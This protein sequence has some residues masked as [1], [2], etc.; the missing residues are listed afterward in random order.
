MTSKTLN[1]VLALAVVILAVE[2]YLAKQNTAAIQPEETGEMPA[3]T[4]I[5]QR[6][7]V[8]AYSDQPVE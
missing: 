5:A 1:I 2:L 7:S 8:R 4:A 6:T 3:L